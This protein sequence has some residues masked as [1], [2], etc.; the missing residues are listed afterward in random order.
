MMGGTAAADAAIK[1]R[2]KMVRISADLLNCP[3]DRIEM[4]D[5]N[6]YDKKN[7]ETKIPFSDIAEEL[8]I[9]GES[10]GVYGF[11]ASP[12]RFFNPE[13]GLGV[14][15]SVYTFAASVAEVEVDTETGH[16]EVTKIWP[17]MDVGKAIDPLII[18][19][20]IHGAISH[21]LGFAAMEN[22][23]LKDGIVMTPGFKDY[24]IPSALDTPEIDDT[25]IVE[26]P[27]KYSAF[28]AKGV[29]EPSII[30]V[31]PAIV[32]AIYHAT[33]VRFST[34]PVTPERMHKAFK[35]ANRK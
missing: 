4:R 3:Q 21:G 12:K 20:Q 16:V 7:H 10:P 29:G 17:A 27:Y 18:D 31:V 33:G 22:L 11:Y 5:S 15:Y 32:N 35:E 13:T 8:H 28:G 26:E 9:R 34:I 1:L 23:Q 24:I 2:E 14:N 6:V 19:G 25:I 30:S